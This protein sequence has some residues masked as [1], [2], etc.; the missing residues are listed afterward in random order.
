MQVGCCH[1]KAQKS[2]HA[3]IRHEDMLKLASQQKTL[4]A[5]IHE[6]VIV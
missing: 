4:Q 3:P 2:D 5:R 1:E 6:R